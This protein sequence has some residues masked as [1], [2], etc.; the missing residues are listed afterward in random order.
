M[1]KLN[2]NSEVPLY[3]QIVD[4]TKLYLAKGLLKDGDKFPSVRELSKSLSINQ[5]TVS[6]AFKELDRL[7]LI[8]TRPGIGTFIRIDQ[9]KID[10]NKDEFTKNL[11]EDFTKAIF[12][13]FAR[14]EIL[15][16]FDET[17]RSLY[18]DKGRENK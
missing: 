4:E 8:E 7:G 10:T 11:R 13:G 14:E 16:I 1:F 3:M 6:K 18:E 5:T 2:F 12:L 9:S 17:E 15:A